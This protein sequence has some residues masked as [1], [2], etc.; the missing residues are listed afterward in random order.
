MLS[1][2]YM[3]KHNNKE[4]ESVTKEI[5]IPRLMVLISTLT[6]GTLIQVPLST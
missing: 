2:G 3:H 5:Y 1:S 4:G 6:L